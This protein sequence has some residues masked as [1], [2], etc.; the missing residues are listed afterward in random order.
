MICCFGELDPQEPD[1]SLPSGSGHA[2]GLAAALFRPFT[3]L[4]VI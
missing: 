3:D 2:G 1:V 4:F